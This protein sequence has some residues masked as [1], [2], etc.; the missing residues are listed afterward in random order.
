MFPLYREKM[1]NYN[2]RT[3]QDEL[4]KGFVAV[5]RRQSVLDRYG[6]YQDDNDGGDIPPWIWSCLVLQGALH[7]PYIAFDRFVV[8]FIY[9][10]VLMSHE[11]QSD[12]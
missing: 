5:E 4:N 1:H 8:P 2:M 9:E 7:P 3:R 12:E 11:L 10:G 6:C